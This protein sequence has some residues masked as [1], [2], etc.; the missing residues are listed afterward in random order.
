MSTAADSLSISNYGYNSLYSDPAWQKYWLMSQQADSLAAAQ[1]ANA[2]GAL[3]QS[4]KTDSITATSPSFQGAI[5]RAAESSG[6]SKIVAGATLGLT[7]LAGAT[8][9]IA[10]RGK[11]AGAKGFMNQIKAGFKS[12]GKSA[13]DAANFEARKVGKKWIVSIPKETR[14]LKGSSM[15][16]ESKSLGLDVSTTLEWTDKAAKL[17]ST[18]LEFQHN[19]HTKKALYRD[20]K[21]VKCFGKDGKEITNIGSGLQAELDKFAQALQS[22]NALTGVTLKDTV[23][24]TTFDGGSALYIANS[25]KNTINNGLKII[26]TNRFAAD[27]EKVKGLAIRNPNFGNAL[28][29]ITGKTP[30]YDSW[31][32]AKATYTPTGVKKWPANTVIEIENDTI[33]GIT[34]NGKFYDTNSDKFLIL[35][36]DYES[37]F[38]DAFKHKKDFQIASFGLAA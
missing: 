3:T 28:E 27:S 5:P 4:A 10:S 38:K 2:L 17:K 20:G 30:K 37:V 24:G 7:A 6:S 16:G 11:G 19:G 32:C 31:N 12:F 13:K 8:W 15:I 25:S 1:N 18:W 36:K 14:I 22:K 9:W 35:Q 34:V 23:Y 21:I 29:E 26:K 33:K